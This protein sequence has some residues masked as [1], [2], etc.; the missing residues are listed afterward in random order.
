[1]LTYY[2][3]NMF[4]PSERRYKELYADNIIST[5]DKLPFMKD[6]VG[7]A[8]FDYLILPIILKEARPVGSFGQPL[9]PLDAS[10][11]KKAAYAARSLA[12]TVIPGFWSAPAG[13]AQ[14]YLAPG[15]TEAMP[16]YRWRQ[17]AHALQGKTSVGVSGKEAW[18]SRTLRAIAGSAGVPIQPP[19]PLTYLPDELKEE[20]K[21]AQ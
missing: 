4:T 20:V 8:I 6:P 11:P 10:T 17:V 1:M 3:L 16:S 13:L 9:Y 12:D 19:V 15:I 18:Q 14:G 2:S 5:I 7:S 21:Q